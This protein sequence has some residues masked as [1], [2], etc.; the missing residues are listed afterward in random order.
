MFIVASLWVVAP[1]VYPN[2]LSA[3]QAQYFCDEVGRLVAVTDGQG[4]AAV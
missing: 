3:D 4:N 2:V 1:L